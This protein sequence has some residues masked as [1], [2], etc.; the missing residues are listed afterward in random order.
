MNRFKFLISSVLVSSI[1]STSALAAV[2]QFNAIPH[3]VEVVEPSNVPSRFMGETV[4]VTFLVDEVGNPSEIKLVDHSDD[5]DLANSLL[6]AVAQWKFSPLQK[7]G[8]AISHRVILPIE[9]VAQK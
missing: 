8:E 6:P 9:L 2:S 4:N 1:L 7:D 5:A 3:P